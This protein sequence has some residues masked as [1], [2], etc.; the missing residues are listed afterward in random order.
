M[1]S[2]FVTTDT[3][4]DRILAR[5]VEEV[6]GRK[7][8]TSLAS[9]RAESEASPFPPRDMVAALRKDKVALIAEVKRASPSKGLLTADFAPVMIAATYAFNGAAAISVLTDADFFMGS[10][11]YLRA[12][13]EAVDLPLLRKD[14]VI[15]PYQVY[16]ART[17]GADNVL[18]IVAALSDLQLGELQSLAHDCGM[19]V[20]VEVHNEVEMERALRL[21]AKLIGINN[22]DLKTFNVDLETTA[23]L[24]GMVDDDVVLVAESGIRDAA[25]VRTMASFGADAILVGESL[26]KAPDMASL[27]RELSGQRRGSR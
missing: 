14:F 3:V 5:K 16:E 18:L 1:T 10:L 9:L 23:R 21:G 11:R 8:K 7:S 4:L 12:V 15:D 13:R 27:T 24:A 2:P 26:V 17:A 25:D 6:A 19:S 20:L 22:R